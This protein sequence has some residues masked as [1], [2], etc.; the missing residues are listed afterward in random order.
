METY[1]SKM[2]L[3]GKLL[4]LIR[5]VLDSFRGWIFSQHHSQLRKLSTN[6]KTGLQVIVKWIHFVL[7]VYTTLQ[8]SEMS[9]SGSLKNG[10]SV[11]LVYFECGKYG[12][13]IFIAK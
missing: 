7:N 6:Q 8:K 5:F 10:I 4:F 2:D 1:C 13:N 9:F 12:F 3:I 11:F